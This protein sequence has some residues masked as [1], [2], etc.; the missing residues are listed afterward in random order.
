M[1]SS[2][3]KFTYWSLLGLAPGSDQAALK[4]AYRREAK[5]WHPDLNSGSYKAHERFRWI[6]KAYEV[7]SDPRSR[8]EWEIA[9][10]PTIEIKEQEEFLKKEKVPTAKAQS[11]M[12]AD[13][14]KELFSPAEKLLLLLISLFCLT[15][16]NSL[17]N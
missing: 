15:I 7:L 11:K 1:T 10:R 6:I 9:G 8:F 2:S 14:A 3:E 4:K 16:L 17:G 5:R 12:A 13:K